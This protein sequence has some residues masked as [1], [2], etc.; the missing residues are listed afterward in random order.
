LVLSEDRRVAPE[1]FPPP[2]YDPEAT[3]PVPSPQAPEKKKAKIGADGKQELA[4]GSMST[5]LLHDVSYLSYLPPVLI[6]R[7]IFCFL[8]LYF[9]LVDFCSP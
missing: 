1:A 9:F 5:P 3:I 2:Q 8:V 6:S 4:A 7:A